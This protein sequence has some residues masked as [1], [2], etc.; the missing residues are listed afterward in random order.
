MKIFLLILVIYISIAQISSR[1]W[2]VFCSNKVKRKECRNLT[3]KRARECSC[4]TL[5][6]DK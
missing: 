6:S 3:C 5:Y 1:Y 2:Y 4:N